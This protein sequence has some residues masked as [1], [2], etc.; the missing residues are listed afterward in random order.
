MTVVKNNKNTSM[1]AGNFADKIVVQ[2]ILF[3]LSN[4]HQ[5]ARQL[6]EDLNCVVHS[7]EDLIW[8]SVQV[9]LPLVCHLLVPPLPLQATFEDD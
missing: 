7:S 8:T 4:T 1:S 3:S 6:V 2:Y 9:E 5:H